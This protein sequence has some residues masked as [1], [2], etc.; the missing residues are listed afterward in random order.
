MIRIKVRPPRY[1]LLAQ[2]IL[3]NAGPI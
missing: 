2:G 1:I 3:S